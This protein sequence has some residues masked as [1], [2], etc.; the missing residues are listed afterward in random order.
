MLSQDTGTSLSRF[1]TCVSCVRRILH[2]QVRE[3]DLVGVV[4][5]GQRVET[6]VAPTPKEHGGSRLDARI[7]ALQAQTLGGTCFFDAIAECLQLL[8]Q[9]DLAAP[10]APRW[11]VCL[12]DGD[13]LGSRRENAGGEMVTRMLDAE[14]IT[15]NLNMVMITVGKLKE[16]NLSVIDSWVER[17][18]TAGNIARHLSNQDAASISQAF[19]VVAEC[20]AAEVGGA[21]EC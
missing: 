10:T 11:L 12:T 9:R 14:G 8:N 20:L 19:S 17:V 16:K 13:D 6:V 21:T 1:D 15:D 5:F 4:G 2:Q 18:A 7:A 3:R